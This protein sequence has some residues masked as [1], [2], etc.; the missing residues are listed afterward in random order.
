[1]SNKL[2][3]YSKLAK[4]CKERKDIADAV[5]FGSA[6]KGKIEP[7]DIDI[8]LI[9]REKIDFDFVKKLGK[10]FSN[11]HISALTV[12]NFF[13]NPHSLAAT[14]LFEGTSILS[15]KP[16]ASVYGLKAFSLYKYELKG[17]PNLIKVSLL[18]ALK[19][20]NSKKGLV[21]DLGGEFVAPCSFIMPPEKDEEMLKFLAKWQAKY[22]RKRILIIS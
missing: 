17:M 15:K 7:G 19:G 12:D 6:V 1:M 2:K 8:C 18:H 16:L 11:S 13:R 21:A 4:L 10:I 14:L 9:F 3:H 5:A 20:R 22:S